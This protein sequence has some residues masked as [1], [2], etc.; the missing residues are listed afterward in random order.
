MKNRNGFTLIELVV[1]IVIL[2][3]LAVVA[4]PRFINLSG[5]ASGASISG[6]EAALKSALKFAEARIE[7]DNAESSIDYEGETISLTGGYPAASA[8]TLRSLLQIEVPSSWTRNW[9]TVPC[10]EPEF[11]ILGNMYPGKGGYIE[12]PN[13]PLDSNGGQDRASYIWPRGYVLKTNGCYAY[14]INEASKEVYHSGS[15]QTGC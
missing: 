12:V 13:H 2:G 8:G 14:Y 1:V 10:D 6:V 15:I 5:D 3:V 11:C 7:I 9:E 4:A